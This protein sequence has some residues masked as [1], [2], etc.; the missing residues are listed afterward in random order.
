MKKWKLTTRDHIPSELQPGTI[1]IVSGVSFDTH[2]YHEL[3]LLL[4]VLSL[5]RISLHL[6]F[7]CL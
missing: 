3:G 7:M 1:L 5:N 4:E 2:I 6:I